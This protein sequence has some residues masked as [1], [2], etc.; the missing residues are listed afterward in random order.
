MLSKSACSKGCN[1]CLFLF[2]LRVFSCYSSWTS[3]DTILFKYTVNNCEPKTVGR[4]TPRWHKLPTPRSPLLDS[5]SFRTALLRASNTLSRL[6]VGKGSWSWGTSGMAFF[7]TIFAEK[8]QR[9]TSNLSSFLRM[10]VDTSKLRFKKQVSCQS[11][12]FIVT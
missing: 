5:R 1:V 7:G 2:F 3:L 6:Q 12:S 4:G 11:K 10:S 8:F 9:R